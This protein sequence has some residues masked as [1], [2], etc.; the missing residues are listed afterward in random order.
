MNTEGARKIRIII[1]D[2]EQLICSML[3][4][5]IR[6]DELGVEIQGAAYDGGTLLELI[7]EKDPDI[8]ITD[9]CMPVMDG[10]DV[11]RTVKESGTDCRFVIIS[12]Y[13]QFDYAYNALKYGVSDYLLKPID[14]QELNNVLRTLCAEVRS[15]LPEEADLGRQYLAKKS[16]DAI[17]SA[18]SDIDAVNDAY[19]TAF[20]PGEFR[21]LYIKFDFE[22]DADALAENNVKSLRRKVMEIA[23]EVLAGETYETI[24]DEQEDGVR[25]LINSGSEKDLLSGCIPELLKQIKSY[26]DRFSG[27]FVTLGV[28]RS[29]GEIGA[30]E[31]LFQEASFAVWKRMAVGPGGIIAWKDEEIAE[32]PVFTARVEELVTA[33]QRSFDDLNVGDF[34]SSSERLFSMSSDLIL[35]P[36]A[37][38]RIMSLPDYFFQRHEEL[39]EQLDSSGEQERKAR[40]LLSMAY[41]LGDYARTFESV[42]S[43]MMGCI[44]ENARNQSVRPVRLAEAYIERHYAEP[45]S[46]DIVAQE[47]NLSPAYFSTVFKKET[48][49]S[50]V[51]YIAEFRVKKAKELLKGSSFNINQVATAVG[52]YDARYFSRLFKKITGMTPVEYRKVFG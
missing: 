10:L 50:F 49:S 22:D 24:Y 14:Q 1:A 6:A 35:S 31:R 23:R 52:F 41:T 11:I 39:M 7:R 12:G 32:S 27:I 42:F 29:A 37:V 13:R 40:Y 28:S 15:S 18:G 44:I 20:R 17:K 16:I 33:I 25:L 26:T 9:I 51:D 45:L 8:V 48:G 21:A 36:Y 46:L 30:A 19:G 5:L 47:V 43:S 3:T 2:D 38:K 4:R 34:T